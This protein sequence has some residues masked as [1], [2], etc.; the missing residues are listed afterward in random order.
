MR[1][2]R[3]AGSNGI[4]KLL[5]KPFS[6]KKNAQYTDAGGIPK[7]LEQLCHVDQLF[8]VMQE[9]LHNIPP[10]IISYEQLFMRL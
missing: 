5:H 2:C 7:N 6:F 10:V 9:V 3:L 4:R 1:N 8:L